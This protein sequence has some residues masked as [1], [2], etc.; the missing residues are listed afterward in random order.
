MSVEVSERKEVKPYALSGSGKKQQVTQ[1]FN[2]IAH[3][4]DLLNHSLSMGIDIVWR[5]KTIAALNDLKPKR[6]LDVATGTGDLALAA[7][8]LNPEKVTGVDISDGML[9][10]GRKKVKARNMDGR[11]ELINGDSEALP[12][13]NAAFDA[14]TVAFGVRNFENLHRGLCEMQRVIRPGGR[15][16]VLEFSQPRS[17][18]IKQ[19]Y[20]F[21]FDHLLPLFGKVVSKDQ[22]AYTYLPESVKHFP[23]GE[24]F[25]AEMRKAGFDRCNAR[26]LTFG[27]ATLYIGHVPQG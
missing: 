12:F 1:M 16:A 27:I 21:Y 5:K 8:S 20:W 11:V 17:F 19:L 15:I 4:Y 18:P 2:S 7:L 6:I 10:L 24:N 23:D 13:A 26:P 3:R 14:A 25:L 9:D 22:S